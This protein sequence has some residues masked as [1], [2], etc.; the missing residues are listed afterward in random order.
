MQEDYSYTQR[1]PRPQL[2]AC[3]CITDK[4]CNNQL[5]YDDT[6]NVDCILGY[7]IQFGGLHWA[8]IIPPVNSD[9]NALA[10]LSSPCTPVSS[11]PP[12]TDPLTEWTAWAFSH[13]SNR[14]RQSAASE[15]V[16]ANP[17]DVAPYLG[18]IKP[19]GGADIMCFTGINISDLVEFKDKGE[20][21]YDLCVPGYCKAGITEYWI[22]TDVDYPCDNNRE[23]ILCGQCKPGYAVTPQSLICVYE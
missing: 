14:S 8:G 16:A 4:P 2:L 5:K 19:G 18:F 17:I 1:I 21:F 3:N 12:F 9:H 11:T 13:D 22:V 20:F 6:K 23:G 15:I 7:T 10:S